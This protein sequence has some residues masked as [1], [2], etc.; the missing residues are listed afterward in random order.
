MVVDGA[1]LYYADPGEKGSSFA[2]CSLDGAPDCAPIGNSFVRETSVGVDEKY[3]YYTE[4]P[5]DVRPTAGILRIDKSGGV[6]R[7]LAVTGRARGLLVGPSAVYWL[8][9][10]EIW[11]VAK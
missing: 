6:P 9:G 5:S 10:N 7:C 1:H 4:P 3:F 2:R 8:D 11:R